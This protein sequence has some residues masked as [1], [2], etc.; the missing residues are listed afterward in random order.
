M[1]LFIARLSINF[2]C[3]KGKTTA[4]I[5]KSSNKCKLYGQKTHMIV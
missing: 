2:E 1:N 3:R 4:N 5:V